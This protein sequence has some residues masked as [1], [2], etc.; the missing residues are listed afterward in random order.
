MLATV[1]L[2]LVVV[3][4]G[5]SPS[6]G[7]AGNTLTVVVADENNV[8]VPSARVHLEGPNGS[9]TCETDFTG[10]CQFADLT[11]GPWQLRVEKESYYVFTL[12]DAQASGTLDISLHHQQEV[13]ETV[14]VV[15][16][17]P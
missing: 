12:A 1:V 13:R 14:N 6:P 4:Q 7:N 8:A 16:S 11:R 17:T 2:G 10:R 15:E 3:L 5:Q 9:Y